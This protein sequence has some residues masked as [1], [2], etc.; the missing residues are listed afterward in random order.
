MMDLGIL[1]EYVYDDRDDGWLPT[2]YENDIMGG[3]RL[4]VNDMDDSNILL[5][6]I[7]DIHVGST[8]IAVEASRRIGESVRI[9]LDASFFINMDK[10]DPAFSLAQ[11]DLIKLELVWY[12]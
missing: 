3:L 12:W 8:I 7:R 10:E 9:N 4:A 1:G 5:G 6:V 2:I 11:D